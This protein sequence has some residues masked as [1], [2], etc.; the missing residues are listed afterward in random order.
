MKRQKLIKYTELALFF[1]NQ[2][3]KDGSTKVGS[4]VLDP[5]SQAILTRGY[6]GMPRGADEAPA[7]RHERPLKYAFYEH[8]ERN[9]IYN[10]ARPLLKG[11]IAITT[12]VPTT[13]CIRALLSVGVS[14]VVM[15]QAA[16]TLAEQRDTEFAQVMDLFA[17]ADVKVSYLFAGSVMGASPRHSR[18]VAAFVAVAEHQAYVLS[19]DPQASASLFVSKDDY[20]LL[21]EGYS[22]MPRGA[23]DS[24]VKRYES[25]LREMWVETSVRNAIYNTV[26]PMLK[27]SVATVT[28][29]TC[30]ECAR[31]F[32]AVGCSEVA[33]V[34]PTPDLVSRW[35]SS[36][37]TALDLLDELG[38]R[39]TKVT[40]EEL[41]AARAALEQR[42]AV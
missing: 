1:A 32:A 28:A 42:K 20:T 35:G 19:K 18:K 34:E 2:F 36:F 9:A 39:T 33:Y 12:A 26:R 27:G 30:V 10:K 16:Q 23:D 17:E 11:S 24:K 29:T 5:E 14:E 25:P 41:G 40:R 15:P 31:A 37:Q 8:A 13:S 4:L 22:G 3:S 21:A 38:V 7:G 6:N